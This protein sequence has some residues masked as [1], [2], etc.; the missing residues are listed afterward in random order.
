MTTVVLASTSAYRRSLLERILTGFSQAAP[1]VDE[2]ARPGEA[3]DALA[4]RLAIAKARAVAADH[5]GRVVVGSDQ[6]A[7][8]GDRLLGKPGDH[9][10]AREQLAACSGRTVR[11]LTAVCVIDATGCE[12][13]HLDT[14]AVRFRPLEERQIESYLQREQPYDCA[15]SF[16][17]EG[18]GIVLFEHID[19][20][21]PTAL[22]GLPLIALARMLRDAGVDPLAG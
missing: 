10:R 15:G 3:P 11:F 8:L 2:S 16:K 17:C 6:V 7:A 12:Q 22:V 18:L 9:A 19:S 4:R 21:D 13:V 1:A 5:P 20:R 14:T